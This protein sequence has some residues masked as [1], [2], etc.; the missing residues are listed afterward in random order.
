MKFD[1]LQQ[2]IT[3]YENYAIISGFD[4]R[5]SSIKKRKYDGKI[6]LKYYVCSKEGFRETPRLHA[7]CKKK[8]PI[9]RM[10]CKARLTLKLIN[11][12][13]NY[14]IF[15]FHEGHTH[16]LNTPNSAHHKKQYRNLTLAHKKNIMDNSRAN[17]RATK[18]YKLMKEHV[19]G[20]ENMA[21]SVTDF[22]N[23]HRDIR[24]QIRG[25]DAQM[26]IEKKATNVQ[27]L[28]I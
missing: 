14:V 1:T 24:K 10:G 18:S 6:L 15:S 20:Y 28:Q 23:F 8:R 11:D 17:I 26:L 27:L 7:E 3:F 25:K 9:I 4:T 16:A 12:Q 13:D 5:L 21:A 22:K 19:G 2:G